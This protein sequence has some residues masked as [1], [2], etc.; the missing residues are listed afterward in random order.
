MRV[1]LV[2]PSH[3]AAEMVGR[4]LTARDHEVRTFADGQEALDCIKSDPDVSAVITAPEPRSLSG[5][6]LCW[7]TRLL[8]G[9]KRPIYVILMSAST[10]E[11]RLTQALGF[12]SPTGSQ[13]VALR[14]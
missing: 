2:E 8:A 14:I 12:C 13:E 10:S 3:T 1:V 5:L 11:A 7:E 6:E 9:S 4:M